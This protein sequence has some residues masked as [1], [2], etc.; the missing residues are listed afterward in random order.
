VS[1]GPAML[2]VILVAAGTGFFV[3]AV[4]YVL[5]CERM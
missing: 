3:L 1:G 5:A 4:L 2:D